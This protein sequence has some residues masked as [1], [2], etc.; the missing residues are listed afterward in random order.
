MTSEW[1]AEHWFAGQNT[2]KKTYSEKKHFQKVE[3][4]VNGKD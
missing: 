3:N 1:H 2:Q 4:Y